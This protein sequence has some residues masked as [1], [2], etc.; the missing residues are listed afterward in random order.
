MVTAAP[1]ERLRAASVLIERGEGARA[2]RVAI[3]AIAAPDADVASV[4]AAAN[5]LM[6]GWDYRGA[7]FVADR[8]RAL[9]GAAE[10]GA[11]VRFNVEH[12]LGFYR[13]S[14]ATLADLDPAHY[15]E[16]HE[17]QLRVLVRAGDLDGAAALLEP[18]LAFRA[19]DERLRRV[20]DELDAKRRSTAP[21]N[22]RDD[23]RLPL[24]T[25]R[26]AA[27]EHLLAR[28]EAVAARYPESGLPWAHHG[29]ALTW[30]GRHDEARASLERALAIERRTRWPHYGLAVLDLVEGRP[31]EAIEWC[32]RGYAAMGN[33]DTPFE[34]A[35]RAEALRL[36]GR[37]EEAAAKL[38]IAVAAHPRRLATHVN[39]GLLH[40]ATG[41]SDGLRAAF[42]HVAEHAPALL[43]AGAGDCGV[44][45]WR[46]EPGVPPWPG[47]DDDERARVL[48]AVLKRMHGNRSASCLTWLSDERVVR[49]I[50]GPLPDV[51]ARHLDDAR[52][53]LTRRTPR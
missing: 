24:D 50:D 13:E 49:T 45:L 47:L 5:L 38:A 23:A 52:G 43:I 16:L 22:A 30:L 36:L 3:R 10:R 40:A 41:R 34:Q 29:E 46:A 15:A 11:V 51:A 18:L 53:V 31:H 44:D 12:R 28:I 39:L 42:G 35:V 7:L 32:D 25:I 6:A 2:R 48:A 9:P 33:T 37:F 21:A 19:D 14:R 17:R 27:P 26:T 8:A 1:A 4:L 20:A